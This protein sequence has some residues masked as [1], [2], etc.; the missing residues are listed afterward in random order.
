MGTASAGVSG[1][2]GGGGG[3]GGS[4]SLAGSGESGSPTSSTKKKRSRR[5]NAK[6][7]SLG[8]VPGADIAAAVEAVEA[9]HQLRREREREEGT[10]GSVLSS[11]GGTRTGSVTSSGAGAMLGRENG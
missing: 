4:T 5:P 10:R 3:G 7:I 2:F 8:H 11:T 9:D 6:P 1:S